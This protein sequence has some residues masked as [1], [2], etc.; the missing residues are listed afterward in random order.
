MLA[1]LCGLEEWGKIYK[2]EMNETEKIRGR[3]L[4]IIFNLPISTSYIG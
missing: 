1:L 3:T 2:D 4:E